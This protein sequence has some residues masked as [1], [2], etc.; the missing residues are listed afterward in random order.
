MAEALAAGVAA[1]GVQDGPAPAAATAGDP[2][3]AA[4][5]ERTP[6]YARRIALF[7][8]HH[9]KRDAAVAAARAANVPIAITLPDGGQRSGVKGATTPLDVAKDISAGLAKKVVVAEVDGRPWDLARPLEGDCALKLFDFD[10]PEGKD[11]GARGA[12][13]AAQ[14]PGQPGAL[15]AAACVPPPARPPAHARRP[16]AT[17]PHHQHA[18]AG[19][20]RTRRPTG[21]R[22]RT[23]WA[24]RWS[25]SLGWT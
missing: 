15:A 7:E 20:L 21:T 6:Y 22:A 12:A 25:W 1:M 3:A 10:S 19:A 13:A 8:E 2:F 18:P 9:R 14:Q 4:V 5:A 23:C 16:A 17:A 11:V 24:R